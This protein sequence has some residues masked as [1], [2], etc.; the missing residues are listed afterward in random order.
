M[1]LI[2]LPLLKYHRGEGEGLYYF[3]ARYLDADIGRWISPDPKE[4]FYDLYAYSG[5]GYN[6]I[7]A[8]DPNGNELSVQGSLRFRFAARS[9]IRSLESQP[10]GRALVNTLRESKN[11]FI[12]TNKITPIQA[13]AEKLY[14][15]NWNSAAPEDQINAG[16]GVGTGGIARL[17]LKDSQLSTVDGMQAAPLFIRMGHELSHLEEFNAGINVTDMTKG[18]D[19]I[20]LGEQGAMKKD[21]MI[22][23]EHGIPT[24]DKY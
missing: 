8:I 9:A 17:S 5:N 2:K 3:G 15:M 13:V 11:N 10:V 6:P 1:P 4:Q 16:N 21:N 23:Q 24:R 12:I 7:N 18:S 19:G 22:R 20:P 14:K